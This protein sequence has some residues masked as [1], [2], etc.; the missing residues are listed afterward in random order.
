MEIKFVS[1]LCEEHKNVIPKNFEACVHPVDPYAPKEICC[2]EN[3]VVVC[4]APAVVRLVAWR[5]AKRD[6][7]KALSEFAKGGV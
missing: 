7:T 6:G 1:H 2:F 3:K 4:N 5:G